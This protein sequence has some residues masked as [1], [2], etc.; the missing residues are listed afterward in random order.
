MGGLGGGI[1]SA[2]NNWGALNLGTSTGLAPMAVTTGGEMVSIAGTMTGPGGELLA[3]TTAGDIVPAAGTI[4]GSTGLTMM[5]WLG[6]GGIALGNILAWS[7]S[8]E[9]GMW[10]TGGTAAGAAIGSIFPGVGTILGAG[11]G[12]TAGSLLGGLFGGKSQPKEG[13]VPGAAWTNIGVLDGKL[14][15]GAGDAQMGNLQLGVAYASGD[16]G[17]PEISASVKTSAEQLIAAIEKAMQL[18]G[19]EADVS[20]NR[21]LIG[22]GGGW[23]GNPNL[24]H[25]MGAVG[26]QANIYTE[27]EKALLAIL[28]S[29]YVKAD[30]SLVSRAIDAS[31][32]TTLD[33]FS[34]DVE[35]AQGLQRAM[36]ALDPAANTLQKQLQALRDA[37]EDSVLKG[38]EPLLEALSRAKDLG[39]ES[40]WRTV[41]EAS[42]RRQFE[43]LA[44]AEELTNTEKLLA[45]IAGQFEGLAEIV[46]RL[47][48]SITQAE[49][50]GFKQAAIVKVREGFNTSIADQLLAIT[51]PNALKLREWERW[52]DALRREAEAS[53]A[54]LV[55]VEELIAARRLAIVKDE[56]AAIERM[57]TSVKEWLERQLLGDTSTLSVP[58]KLTEAQSQF[59]ATVAAVRGGDD[60]AMGAITGKA[61]ALIGILQQMYGST[62]DYATQVD[63]VRSTVSTLMHERGVPGFA[64]GT[65]SA[66]AGWAWVGE[67]GREL[68]R[69]RGG[70]EVIPAAASAALV[71]TRSG[72]EIRALLRAQAEQGME[73]RALRRDLRESG[74]R[75][76]RAL[77][78]V[79]RLARRQ[80]A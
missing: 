49:L 4:A 71:G 42:I 59:A 64:I 28:R 12:A 11:I 53:G 40:E 16:G 47:D 6:I 44:P 18:L 41:T 74:E 61:D 10:T 25:Y 60:S 48:L 65:S 63:W 77:A 70:E 9:M 32:A 20:T 56:Q 37:A 19:L 8:P 72:G 36:D 45:Q 55:E 73:I 2:V 38:I 3:V 5:E 50:D 7:Q 46:D 58:A 17:G 14:V 75:Q 80:A 23:L 43:D 39:M 15:Y 76:E 33:D 52:A 57:G 26:G 68:V 69:F 30:G 34:A 78:A 29:D 66:P 22:L 79:E 31:K 35:F 51:D 21:A 27:P 67:H 1:T 24:Q 62:A 54:D 13:R